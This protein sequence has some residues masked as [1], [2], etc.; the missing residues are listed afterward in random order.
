V[1]D[2]AAG[3]ISDRL[4][5]VGQDRDEPPNHP[6]RLVVVRTEPHP[7]RSAKEC[8][9]RLLLLTNL[10]AGE[11]S[12]DLVGMLYH[13]RWTIELFFRFLKQVQGM[14]HLLG[15]SRKAVEIFVYCIEPRISRSPCLHGEHGSAR[16]SCR[17][18]A[19]S[20]DRVIRGS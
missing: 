14:D 6:V 15:H 16:R 2:R 9:G 11:A 18:R 12:A 1:E 20:L 13:Y 19:Y 7:K 17:V 5:L 10:S 3:V 4:V 8:S